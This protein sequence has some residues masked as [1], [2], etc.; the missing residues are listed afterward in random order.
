MYNNNSNNNNKNQIPM[1]RL[2]PLARTIQGPSQQIHPAFQGTHNR[3]LN[4]FTPVQQQ[5]Q[6]QEVEFNAS[7]T[8]PMFYG[9]IST[10]YSK[11]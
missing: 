11:L 10:P 1:S 7:A 9:Y 2:P 3:Y 6:Q 4:A 8:S 5:Q